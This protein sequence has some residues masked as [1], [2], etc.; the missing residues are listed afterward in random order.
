MITGGWLGALLLPALC[1]MGAHGEFPPAKNVHLL[2]H[3]ELKLVLNPGVQGELP[4][5]LSEIRC[6]VGVSLVSL[7]LCRTLCPNPILRDLLIGHIFGPPPAPGR[8]RVRAPPTTLLIVL[9]VLEHHMLH[10]MDD[11]PTDVLR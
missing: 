11:V 8:V 6:S 2:Y 4:S 5:R 9:C 3:E 10:R 1:L 7:Q